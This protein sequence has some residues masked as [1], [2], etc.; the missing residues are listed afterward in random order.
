MFLFDLTLENWIVFEAAWL[1]RLQLDPFKLP[2]DE[3]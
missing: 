3:E 1:V 2:N